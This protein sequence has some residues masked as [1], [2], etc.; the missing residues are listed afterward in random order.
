MHFGRAFLRGLR[1]VSVAILAAGA[2]NSAMAAQCTLGVMADLPVTMR[3]LRAEVPTKINGRDT[4]FWLDSGVFFSIMPKAK[5]IEFSLP[6]EP[7]PSG[8]Y[9]TGIGGTASVELAT[10]KSFGIVGHD[11]KNVRFLV[12]GTDSGNGL[13]GRNLL[14][15]ADT[16]FDLANGSVKLVK[17]QN[18]GNGA[19]AYWTGGKPWFTVPLIAGSNP[20]DHQFRLPVLIN[21]AK[22]VAVFDTGA[23]Y[24]LLSR[25]AAERAGIDLS[26]PDVVASS[27]F[28]GF[29][30][31]TEKG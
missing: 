15:I 8:F 19:L 3:G 18:C 10:I 27:G 25:H 26:G 29:G 9:I 14:G 28:G 17:P 31:R 22:I 16:E 13:I 12:G 30:R 1:A 5:A 20:K 6:L 21:G 24:S 7:L 4:S 23:P 11:I 2:A